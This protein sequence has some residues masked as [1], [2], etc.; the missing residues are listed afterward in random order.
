MQSVILL[1]LDHKGKRILNTAGGRN[2]FFASMI[3]KNAYD[4]VAKTKDGIE[5]VN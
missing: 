3:R 2:T 5:G 1:D 4:Y